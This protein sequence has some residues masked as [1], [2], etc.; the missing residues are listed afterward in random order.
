MPQCVTICRNGARCRNKT[1]NETCA[2]HTA[3][4]LRE[5]IFYTTRDINNLNSNNQHSQLIGLRAFTKI[6]NEL[7]VR[8]FLRSNLL[9]RILH[10]CFNSMRDDVR[11][12]AFWVLINLTSAPGDAGSRAIMNVMPN[13]FER[14]NDVFSYNDN[15]L[16]TNALWCLSNMAASLPEYSR[17]MI[18]LD[19]HNVCIDY[20]TNGRVARSIQRYAAFLL[21][22]LAPSTNV[23]LA[24]TIM[25]SLEEIPPI[26]LSD[27]SLMTDLAWVMNKLYVISHNIKKS[28]VLF[29]C[30][31]LKSKYLRILIP[32]LNTI[33]EICSD[34]KSEPII[35]LI[36]ARVLRR[37]QSFLSRSE[38]LPSV[39]LT[40]SNIAVE[41]AGSLA[42][43]ETPGLLLDIMSY[44]DIHNDAVF[45]IANLAARGSQV[46]IDA[47]LHFSCGALLLRCLEN[48][49]IQALA[50]E[51]IHILLQKG[52]SLAYL[53]LMAHNIVDKISRLDNNP[54]ILSI[55]ELLSRFN[56]VITNQIVHAPVLLNSTPSN[57]GLLAEGRMLNMISRGNQQNVDVSDLLFTAGDIGYL[58]NHNYV[59][60]PDG[61]LTH[62]APVAL[63]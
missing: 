22:N 40:L 25:N 13:F 20:L 14:I 36:E 1:S 53:Q 57:S 28:N 51:G 44:K 55:N 4:L 49:K 61:Q 9:P 6:Q 18:D 21:S 29:L 23:E 31:L 19:I 39:L 58:T 15:N 12:T 34:H 30:E 32:V 43:I 63:G 42:I 7:N 26:I 3:A 59:F 41:S 56:N 37:L 62:R 38:L 8:A 46:V 48:T 52:G 24:T 50:L 35:W 60:M 10:L 27:V 2:L 47:L 54:I 45:T 5:G 17:N 33:V 16:I 11:D